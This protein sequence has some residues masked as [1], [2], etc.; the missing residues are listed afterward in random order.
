M[1][2]RI[3]A[4][5]DAFVAMASP[6]A[7]RPALDVDG[8]LNALLSDVGKG[9]DRRVVAAL[10]NF[11]DNKGG[12]TTWAKVSDAKSTKTPPIAS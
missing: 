3:V 2:A 8:V 11:M 5:A 9:Y 12:R 1:T 4:V 6:R 10:T 7:H